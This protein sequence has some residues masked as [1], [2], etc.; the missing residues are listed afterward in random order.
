MQSSSAYLVSRLASSSLL[1]I[2][3]ITGT[4]QTAINRHIAFQLFFFLLVVVRSPQS[5]TVSRK[6]LSLPNRVMA[7]R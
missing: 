5:C 4:H 1:N 3:G 2:V 7:T 6:V